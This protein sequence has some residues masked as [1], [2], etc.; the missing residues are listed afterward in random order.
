MRAHHYFSSFTH[1]LNILVIIATIEIMHAYVAVF[2]EKDGIPS[3][4]LMMLSNP[5]F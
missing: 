5:L 2:V 1:G 4:L 3:T